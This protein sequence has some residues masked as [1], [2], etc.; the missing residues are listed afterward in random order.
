MKQ[1]LVVYNICGL[2]GRDNTL[3]YLKSID[4]I[5]RQVGVDI[6]VVVSGCMVD[7]AT[8]EFLVSVFQGRGV[9]FNFINEVI[10]VNASFNHT[11]LQVT[12]DNRYDGY[13]YVDSGIELKELDTI[14]RLYEVFM[15]G[16]YGIVSA[17]A[18]TDNGADQWFNNNLGEGN[19]FELPVGGAINSH[20][21]IW[22]DK[23][24]DFYNRLDPDIFAS[25]CAESTFTFLCA[26]IKLKCVLCK[27]I[28]VEHIVGIDGQSSGF[29]P[30]DWIR[31][32]RPTYDHPYR[33][34][35]LLPIFDN[36]KARSLGLG[37]EEC[38]GVV[39]HDASQYDEDGF[40]VNDELKDYI[41]EN[42]FLPK[43]LLDY[44]TIKNEYIK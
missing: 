33:L 20:F 36:P 9:K 35:S 19:L 6:D 11:V 38:R 34:D 31:S 37:F 26:A 30:V 5:L 1:L 44:D 10:P 15:S 14:S 13:L 17:N 43:H 8:K 22:S 42:L 4:S 40:C 2:S 12:K 3:Y 41:K 18:T 39:M 25:H 27:D 29:S 16:P 28:V 7:A 24:L 23:I 21:D 32:G